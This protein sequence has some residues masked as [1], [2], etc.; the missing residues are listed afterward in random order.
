[1][2][3]WLHTEINVPHRELNPDTVTHPNTN[4]TGRRLALLFETNALLPEYD[5]DLHKKSFIVRSWYVW[6][7]WIK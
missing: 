5:T 3:S 1:M 4:R 6:I 7:Y 2:N